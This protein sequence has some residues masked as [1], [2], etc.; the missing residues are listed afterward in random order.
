MIFT[1]TLTM[2]PD[3]ARF[4]HDHNVSVMGKLDSLR[5]EVQ[6]FLVGR[7]GVHERLLKGLD[8]LLEAGYGDPPGAEQLRLGISF[9][10]N[11]LNLDELEDVWHFCRRRKIFPNMEVLT[12]TGR[13][14]DELDQYGLG[15]E[16]IQA[17]KEKLLELDRK[18]YGYDWLPHTPLT[19]SG[20]L[21][22]LYSL[23]ITIDGD[24]RPCAP[25]KFDEHPALQEDGVYPHNIHR[26]TLRD[27]YEDDLFVYVRN[28]EKHLVGRC[29]AC[30][31]I[32]ECIGCR[33]YAY[34]VGVNNGLDP[35]TALRQECQQCFR[36]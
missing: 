30:D 35:R 23:Y 18:A 14:R 29:K 6:D 4:L 21:Q 11:R 12:P 2:S 16:E 24:V 22:H 10:S 25:T 17:Y 9:V 28:I 26:R 8:A 33:G 20:C 5:P 7:Q 1:N 32:D 27:I 31:H 19:A 36:A 15:A 13:A 3:L 34:S